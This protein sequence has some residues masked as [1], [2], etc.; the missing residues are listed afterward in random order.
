MSFPFVIDAAKSQE[1]SNTELVF[2][3]TNHATKVSVAEKLK[4]QSGWLAL[5][6]LAVDAFN[7]QEF[8]LL[9]DRTD[10][11][12]FVDS[13]ACKRLF[14]VER[15]SLRSG[16]KTRFMLFKKHCGIPKLKLNR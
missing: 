1:T 15:T 7:R 13:E 4:G 2:D 6:F 9:T 14:E 3:Y 11:G 8:L 16:Q 12:K 5:N 10:N